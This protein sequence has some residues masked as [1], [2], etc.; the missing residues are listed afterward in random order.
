MFECRLPALPGSEFLD[1]LSEPRTGRHRQL[2]FE[3]RADAL[4][5]RNELLATIKSAFTAKAALISPSP[6]RSTTG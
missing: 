5:R 1:K 6:P 4:A 2:F 3:K